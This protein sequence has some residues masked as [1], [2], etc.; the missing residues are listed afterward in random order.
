VLQLKRTTTI[1]GKSTDS[2]D[3]F[4]CFA[5]AQGSQP[6]AWFVSTRPEFMNDLKFN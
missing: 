5:L 1:K 2:T 3:G 4:D 6:S